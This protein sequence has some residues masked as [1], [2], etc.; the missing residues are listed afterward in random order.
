MQSPQIQGYHHEKQGHQEKLAEL[1]L[2]GIASGKRVHG[3]FLLKRVQHSKVGIVHNL[4]FGYDQFVFLHH[5]V[6]QRDLRKGLVLFQFGHGS[7]VGHIGMQ[8]IQHQG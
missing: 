7:I 8:G 6:G 4:A 5:A 3:V 1:H 2:N